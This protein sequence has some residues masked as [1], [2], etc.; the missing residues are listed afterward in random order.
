[1]NVLQSDSVSPTL[2]GI[3]HYLDR[4]PSGYQLMDYPKLGDDSVVGYHNKPSWPTSGFL[5][6][7]SDTNVCSVTLAANSSTHNSNSLLTSYG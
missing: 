1:V 5:T 4:L 2:T 3:N 7:S 6:N